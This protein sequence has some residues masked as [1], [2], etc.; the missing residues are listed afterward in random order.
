M[1][2]LRNWQGAMSKEA[3]TEKE[4]S[5]TKSS[6]FVTSDSGRDSAEVRDIRRS[7]ILKMGR[8]DV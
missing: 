5:Q 4:G 3:A 8:G 7:L 6:I 1:S 2:T